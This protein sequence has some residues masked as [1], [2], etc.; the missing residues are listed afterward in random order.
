VRYWPRK[1]RERPPGVPKIRTA[2]R[3]EIRMAQALHLCTAPN[4]LTALGATLSGGI[5]A[6]K[7]DCA[8]SALTNDFL[9]HSWQGEERAVGPL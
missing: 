5:V 4:W 7:P 6:A 3:E 1:K 9:S 2:T 8:R